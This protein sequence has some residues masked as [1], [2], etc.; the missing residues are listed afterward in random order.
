[1]H[2]SAMKKQISYCGYRF[3]A[4]IISHAVWLYHRFALSFRNVEDLPSELI[5]VFL[6]FH[7]LHHLTCEGLRFFLVHSAY[8]HP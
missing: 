7:T 4:A 3:P 2:N 8:P 1:M 5:Q 6:R